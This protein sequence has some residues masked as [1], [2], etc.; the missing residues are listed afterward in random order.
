MELDLEDFDVSLA[1]DN[2]LVL[3]RERATRK[4]LSLEW[5]TTAKMERSEAI[6]ES[7]NKSS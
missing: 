3:V 7:S 6:S 5:Q 2:A 1:I 4:G